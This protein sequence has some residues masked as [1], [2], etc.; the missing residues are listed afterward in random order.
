MKLNKYIVPSCIIVGLSADDKWQAID[1][2][3]NGLADAGA[4]QD[5][6]QVREDLFAREKKMS[7]GMEGGLA[8]PHAK[9][10]GAK[11]LAV[12]VGISSEGIDFDSLDGNPAHVLFL[13]VSRKDIS[14][15]HIQCLAE[16]ARLYRDGACRRRLLRS[17][18]PEDVIKALAECD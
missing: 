3:L 9:S 7:T 5:R 1:K 18:R 15:P 12:A 6:A 4:V 11:T 2:L 13:V 16:I 14:G 17:S 10:D 8:L